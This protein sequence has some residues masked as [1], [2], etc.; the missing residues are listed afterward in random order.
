MI[1]L[2]NPRCSKSR[3]ALQYLEEKWVDFQVIEYL[4]TPLD[5][6]ELSSLKIKLWKPALDFCRVK[7]AEFEEAG[8]TMESS[9][10]EVLLA[11]SRFPKLIERPILIKNHEA[12]IGR[13]LE[14][15]FDLID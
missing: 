11:M 4:K 5:F 12:R 10:N 9:D 2:H 14:N 15:L 8:L 6:D 7:E 1:L 3:Q 13:P